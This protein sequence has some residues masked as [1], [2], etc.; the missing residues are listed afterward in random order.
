[1]TTRRE[2]VEVWSLAG[3]AALVD[4]GGTRASAVESGAGVGGVR[5]RAQA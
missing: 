2:L 5:V 4:S 1:M 3:L